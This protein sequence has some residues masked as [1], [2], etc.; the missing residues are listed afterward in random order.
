MSNHLFSF[1]R[2]MEESDLSWVLSVEDRVYS[3][4]WSLKGFENSLDQGLNYILCS[5]QGQ[6]LGY[7]C[8]LTV[9]DEA[10]LL[11][12]CVSPDYHRQGVGKAALVKLKE[13]LK[14]SGFSIVFLEVRESNIAAQ[15]LYAQNSFSRDGLRKDY[16]RGLAWSEDLLCQEEV[17][18][19]AV[20][21]SCTL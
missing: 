19:D 6:S 5:E 4:P 14:E 16:Y 9:L 20:L 8:I 10:H 2:P 21:M 1:L 17:K 7:V 3:F 18:E 13:K 12:F 15:A 11:N